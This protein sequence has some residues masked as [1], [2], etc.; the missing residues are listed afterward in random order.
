[1]LKFGKKTTFL[2][3]SMT[4]I[5]YNKD[6]STAKVFTSKRTYFYDFYT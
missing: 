5:S 2:L 3:Y 6:E 4:V 1:M